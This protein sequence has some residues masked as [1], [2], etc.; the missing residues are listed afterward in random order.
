MEIIQAHGNYHELESYRN[1]VLI[2]DATVDFCARFLR[3][4]DRTIDQ[5]T[6]AARSGKQNIVE[7]CK[8]SNF[9]H[10]PRR[11]ENRRRLSPS[12]L[13]PDCPLSGHPWDNRGLRRVPAPQPAV[14]GLPPSLVS[15]GDT[16]TQAIWIVA[17]SFLGVSSGDNVISAVPRRFRAKLSTYGYPM[18]VCFAD[19]NLQEVIPQTLSEE[20]G[21]NL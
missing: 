8:S 4:G 1:A 13:E 21:A 9:G 5:M 20:F 15:E 3:R 12:S 2:Y 7:G 19:E 18:D 17:G 6:Q 10:R 14:K 11:A 16:R